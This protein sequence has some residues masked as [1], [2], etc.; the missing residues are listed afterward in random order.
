M[1]EYKQHLLNIV[2]IMNIVQSAGPTSKMRDKK[3][4]IILI[5]K[6][7]KL[8]YRSIRRWLN[9]IKMGPEEVLRLKGG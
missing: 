7:E 9:N 4:Y 3:S 6:S 2:S 1:N 5:Q 8:I